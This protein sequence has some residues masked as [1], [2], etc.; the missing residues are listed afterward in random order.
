M[1]QR[2]RDRTRDDLGSVVL[3]FALLAPILLMLVMGII[4]FGYML[5]RDS[6]INNAARDAAR[7]ASLDGDFATIQQTVTDELGDAGISGSGLT[8]T[9]CADGSCGSSYDDAAQPGSTVKVTVSYVHHWL[10][11]IGALCDIVGDRCTGDTITL[12]RTAEMVRE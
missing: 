7:V 2:V 6:V 8:V 1:L 4:D 5:N 9:I 3:E 10:T 11:P 12:A